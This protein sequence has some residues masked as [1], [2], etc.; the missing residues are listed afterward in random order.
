MIDALNGFT[1]IV[2][3]RG[4]EITHIRFADV[5]DLIGG[6]NDELAYL[7]SRFDLSAQRYGMKINSENIKIMV[8]N[9]KVKN[10]RY[11]E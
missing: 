2:A 7:T 1:G 10:T 6:Y 11:K 4:R 9:N 5:I 3:V 8:T